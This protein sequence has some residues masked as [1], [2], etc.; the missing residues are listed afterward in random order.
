MIQEQPGDR[1]VEGSDSLRNG[2]QI[3]AVV[4]DEILCAVE[5]QQAIVGFAVI[6]RIADELV[7]R[8]RAHGLGPGVV[9]AEHQAACDTPVESDLK[10]I[11]VGAGAV[12]GEETSRAET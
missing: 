2:R 9:H 5:G 8:V 4:D 11:V 7:I 12:R 10:G 3:V 6:D 1:V